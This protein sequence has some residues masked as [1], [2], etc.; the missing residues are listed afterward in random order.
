MIAGDERDRN[1][2]NLMCK[3][4]IMSRN[5]PVKIVPNCITLEQAIGD[6]RINF[7]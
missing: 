5:K 2:K 3:A 1:V 4:Q 7:E 6:E